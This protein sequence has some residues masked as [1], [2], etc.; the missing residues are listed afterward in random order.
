MKAE[1]NP[2][3]IGFLTVTLKTVIRTLLSSTTPTKE[4]EDIDGLDRL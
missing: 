2:Q 1:N 4:H 3:A